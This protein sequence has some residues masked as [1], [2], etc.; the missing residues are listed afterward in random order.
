MSRFIVKVGIEN[1]SPRKAAVEERL[2]VIKGLFA[3]NSFFEPGEKVIYI[4]T[5]DNNT[6]SVEVVPE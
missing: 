6:V 2:N 3:A 4:P 5:P 1:I